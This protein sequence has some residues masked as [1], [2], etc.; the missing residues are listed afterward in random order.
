MPAQNCGK[1]RQ[2]KKILV[3]LGA[4]LGDHQNP[5]LE[6]AAEKGCSKKIAGL[7]LMPVS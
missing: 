1:P 2:K 7:T 5:N 6:N 3:I 4:A